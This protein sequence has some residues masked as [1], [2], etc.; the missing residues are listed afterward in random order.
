MVIVGIVWLVLVGAWLVLV[1]AW[2]VLVGW[3]RILFV[4]KPSSGSFTHPYDPCRNA[5][6]YIGAQCEEDPG[7]GMNYHC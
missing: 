6:P 2:L 7:R 1:G 3:W 4:G 5:H